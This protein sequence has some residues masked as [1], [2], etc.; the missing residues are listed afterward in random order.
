MKF[1][2]IQTNLH[3]Q[4]IDQSLHEIRVCR[5]LTTEGGWETV[6]MIKTLYIWIVVVVKW[7]YTFVKTR[8]IV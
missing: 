7:I 2:T 5:R 6:G 3:W 4:K 1:E 8:Q